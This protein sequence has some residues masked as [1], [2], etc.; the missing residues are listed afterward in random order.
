MGASLGVV[1]MGPGSLADML[2]KGGSL[3]LLCLY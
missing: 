3:G 1:Q 2:L